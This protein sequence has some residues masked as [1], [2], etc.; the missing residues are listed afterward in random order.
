MPQFVSNFP[1]DSNIHSSRANENSLR[2][3]EFH[4]FGHNKILKNMI[5][6]ANKVLSEQNVNITSKS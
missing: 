1:K 4:R 5:L 2:I 6:R 3:K